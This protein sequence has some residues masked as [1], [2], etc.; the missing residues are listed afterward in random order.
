MSEP[1]TQAPPREAFQF[2]ASATLE[3]A[4]DT[5]G[6]RK[7]SGIGYG[8]GVI[9]DHPFWD[10]V[11]FDLA[12]TKAQS[13]KIPILV[14]HAPSKRAGFAA[15][16]VSDRISVDGELLSNEFGTSVAS[17]AD[18][19]FP[20]QMSVGIFPQSIDELEAG[21]TET[22]NGR[23]VTGPAA[24]FRGSRIREVSFVALGADAETSASVFSGRNKPPT[25]GRSM[26]DAKGLEARIAELESGLKASAEALET[27]K[28][29][30]VA[31]E[32]ELA[33]F[34]AAKRTAEVKEL[35]AAL[36]REHNDE[37]AKPYMEM[38][39]ATFAAVAADMKAT[40]VKAP[41]HLF[42]AQATDGEGSKPI[43]PQVVARKAREF[44]AAAKARGE[45]VSISDAVRAVSANHS[46]EG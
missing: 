37:S 15:V 39:E 20:W 17:E 43:D 27:E 38:A 6:N 11:V 19:G 14:D 41:A 32:T 16:S 29:A 22:V 31:A 2:L 4:P 13:A 45:F 21:Q 10:A 26:S 36:G 9:T 18:A 24:I 46:T 25:E 35:F 40:K 23:E 1:T 7:F 33:N 34:T 8:G 3:A 30:R 42:T 28:A 5:N 12:N 44:K